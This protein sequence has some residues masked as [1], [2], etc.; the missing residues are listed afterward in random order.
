MEQG[1]FIISTD[2]DMTT[3]NPSLSEGEFVVLKDRPGMFKFGNYT[4]YSNL[5]FIGNG[6]GTTE[7]R[8]GKKETGFIYFDTTLHKC[9]VFDGTNWVNMDGTAL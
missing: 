8:P 2:A 6:Y 1:L 4:S 9:I 5:P 7:Q 3:L